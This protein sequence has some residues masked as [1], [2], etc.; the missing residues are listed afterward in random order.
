MTALERALVVYAEAKGYEIEVHIED[1]L[2]NVKGTP[3]F[4]NFATCDY[5]A[6]STKGKPE[7]WKLPRQ[8]FD[9]IQIVFIDGSPDPDRLAPNHERTWNIEDLKKYKPAGFSCKTKMYT[10]EEIEEMNK[11]KRSPFETDS[12]EVKRR[13]AKVTPFILLMEAWAE[14]EEI[15]FRAKPRKYDE[16]EPW[17]KY[18]SPNK[19]PEWNFSLVDYRKAPKQPEPIPATEEE[20][21]EIKAEKNSCFWV[22]DK[23]S[24]ITWKFSQMGV[25]ILEGFYILNLSTKC[26]EDWSSK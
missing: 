1:T 6:K 16:V 8:L 20:L 3:G 24:G 17:G 10:R 22:K 11:P 23:I 19:M 2:W 21:E 18:P 9:A 13:Y 15:E 4:F 12:P 26:W 5:R 7:I 25:D 14:G